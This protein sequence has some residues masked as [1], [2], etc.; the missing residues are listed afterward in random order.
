MEEEY[1]TTSLDELPM[2]ILSFST[3]SPPFDGK[4]TYIV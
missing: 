1:S 2:P 3:L 4:P